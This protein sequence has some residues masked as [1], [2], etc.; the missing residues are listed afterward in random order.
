[1]LYLQHVSRKRHHLHGGMAKLV[2]SLTS[3]VLPVKHS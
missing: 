2:Q 3:P 1:M